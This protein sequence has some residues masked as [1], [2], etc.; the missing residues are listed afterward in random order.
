[1]KF[2]RLMLAQLDEQLEKW[3]I[4][5]RQLKPKKGWVNLIRTA[6][7]MSSRQ[8]A[9]RMKVNQSRI[10]QI[11]SAEQTESVTLKTLTKTAEAM[12]CKLV[13]ALIPNTTLSDIL[14]KQAR[15]VARQRL[16][17]VSHSM[18]LEAQKVVSDKE[19]EQFEEL[20]KELL[21]SPSKK[22]WTEK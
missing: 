17:R 8:L 6:I 19:Q 21:E 22:L 4:V 7:G 18:G 15:K 16:D 3:N 5:K 12:G 11:E 20:V 2:K 14:E 13:Y 9:K 10:M 1:M